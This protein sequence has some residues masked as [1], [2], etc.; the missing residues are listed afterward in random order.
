M[1]KDVLFLRRSVVYN[2]LFLLREILKW[3][4]RPRPHLPADVRHQGPHE[5]IPR[6]YRALIDGKGFIRHQSRTVNSAYDSRSVACPA[7]ALAVEGQFLRRRGVK[8]FPTL[9][10]GEFL[11]RRHKKGW[12]D[13]MSVRT[14]V[15]RQ[16]RHH[17]A[18]AV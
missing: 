11:S 1:V 7:G 17:K 8:F 18:Q 12:F 5:G 13:I 16:S 10:A 2:V 3:H 14:S 4:V 9:R 6:S 15:A